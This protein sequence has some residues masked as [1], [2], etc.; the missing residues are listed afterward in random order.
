M[1]V[2]DVRLDFIKK[3]WKHQDQDKQKYGLP[4]HGIQKLR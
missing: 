4:T 3:K 1:G 2:V